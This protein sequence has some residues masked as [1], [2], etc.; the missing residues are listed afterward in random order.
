M[1]K[2]IVESSNGYFVLAFYG[3]L[4]G[5]LLPAIVGRWWYGSRNLTKDGIETETAARYF[6]AVK[7]N[8]SENDIVDVISTSHEFEKVTHRL[9]FGADRKYLTANDRMN[10]MDTVGLEKKLAQASIPLTTQYPH[11]ARSETTDLSHNL[12][13]AHL[14]RLPIDSAL[15]AEITQIVADIVKFQHG[16]VQIAL[17][18]NF[19]EPVRSAM[20]MSQYIL[21]ALP[22]GSSPLRQLPGVDKKL[23][24]SLGMLEKHPVKGV[25]DLLSLT[26]AERRKALGSLDE[27]QYHLAMGVAKQIPILIVSNAHFKGIYQT[28]PAQPLCPFL[29]LNFNLQ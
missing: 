21:Q 12:I 23:A 7:E 10:K 9:H 4:F 6:R 24:Q 1:P 20:E 13:H 19:Y 25:Q 17:A 26:E 28:S 18:F 11:V 29:R 3:L 5:V 15:E 14:Q 2:W 22:V 8:M 27:Q 16:F